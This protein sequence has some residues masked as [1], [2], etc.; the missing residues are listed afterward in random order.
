[1]LI[2]LI[3][4]A[5]CQSSGK[6]QENVSTLCRN[7]WLVM[8]GLCY[9]LVKKFSFVNSLQFWLKSTSSFFIAIASLCIISEH[10]LLL[11][12]VS[13]FFQSRMGLINFWKTFFLE[14]MKEYLFPLWNPDDGCQNKNFLTEYEEYEELS[15][16]FFSRRRSDCWVLK[17]RVVRVARLMQ[18]LFFDFFS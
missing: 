12:A 16:V 13:C 4:N 3:I 18:A 7:T 6:K 15:C 1:M 17:V 5:S 11:P 10:S 2:N 14:N 9:P 8:S